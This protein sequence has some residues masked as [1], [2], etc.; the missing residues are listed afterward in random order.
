MRITRVLPL[1]LLLGWAGTSQAT[2]IFTTDTATDLIGSWEAVGDV[3]VEVAS[4]VN[5]APLLPGA[6]DEFV[7]KRSNVAAF[8]TFLEGVADDP[9]FSV[10]IPNVLTTYSDIS[11]T[12][13]NNF[14]FTPVSFL[15]F[16]LQD[17]GGTGGTFTGDFCFSTN[18]ET[19]GRLAAVPEP[20]T[21]ALLGAGLIGLLLRRKRV[22]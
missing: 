8:F 9:I 19:C 16:N 21:L 12:Y 11:G 4:A 3:T 5:F 13:S 7:L 18:S 10:L 17:T 20:G 22:T 2:I 14:P 1:V 6:D 15:Y